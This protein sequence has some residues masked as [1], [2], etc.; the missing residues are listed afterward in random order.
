MHI[1]VN[2]LHVWMFLLYTN[3]LTKHGNMSYLVHLHKQCNQ[4]EG[5]GFTSSLYY[6]YM[7]YPTVVNYEKIHDGQ[8]FKTLLFKVF[9]ISQ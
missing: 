9:K 6:Q 5:L 8:Q 1:N 2:V 4:S 7:Y 3:S